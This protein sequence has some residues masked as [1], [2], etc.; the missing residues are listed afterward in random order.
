MLVSNHSYWIGQNARWVF[1]AYDNRA[2]QFDLIAFSAPYYLAV[3][4]AGNDRN[5]VNDPLVGP[6]LNEKFGY[7]LI[8]GMQTGKNFLTVGAVNQVTNYTGPDSVVMSAF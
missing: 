5:D 3:T 4:A 2:R 6:Q 8:R 7:D 1:G